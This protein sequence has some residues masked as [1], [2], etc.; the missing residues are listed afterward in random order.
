MGSQRLIESLVG[1]FVLAGLLA[2]AVLAFKV[3]GLT[4]LFPED[5]YTVTANFDDIGG[6]KV[7][8]PIKIGGVQ[9]GEVSRIDLDKVTF[10]AKVS[11]HILS[12]YDDI[13]DDSSA[14]IFTAGLLGDN[15]IAIAPMY[16]TT[17]L[18]DGGHIEL[19]QSAMILEK[20]IGQF[21]YKINSGSGGDSAAE[22][23]SSKS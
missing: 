18:K 14:G 2:L 21:I 3:S 23:K 10:K 19:T 16:S 1:A 22:T 11:L 6:L 20:L 7:R 9:I 17:F 13:P 8:A 12:K 5:G 4:N 15:Y